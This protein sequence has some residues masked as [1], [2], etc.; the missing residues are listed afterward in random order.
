MSMCAHNRDD[1][2]S[3]DVSHFLFKGMRKKKTTSI[4]KN[5]VRKI[6]LQYLLWMRK[7]IQDEEMSSTQPNVTDVLTSAFFKQPNTL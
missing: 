7:Y 6:V 5:A 3:S 2:V 1:D 4:M